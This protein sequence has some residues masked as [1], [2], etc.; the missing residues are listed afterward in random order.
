[1]EKKSIEK[2]VIERLSS[3]LYPQRLLNGLVYLNEQTK[4]GMY[5]MEEIQQ[6]VPFLRGNTCGISELRTLRRNLRR[7][8]VERI[9][10]LAEADIGTL[11]DLAVLI[12]ALINLTGSLK[13]DKGLLKA[14]PKINFCYDYVK[15][16]LVLDTENEQKKMLKNLKK[17]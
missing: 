13:K 7:Q 5:K 14:N 15:L 10:A 12:F 6:L 8:L 11:Y 16:I 17:I 1:M 3:D 4:T 9:N 2:K